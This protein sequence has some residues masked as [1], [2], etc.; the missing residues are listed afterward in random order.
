MN[1]SSIVVY[2][3]PD[4]FEALRKS[5][6]GLPGIELHYQHY[7]TGQM[8]L[9]QESSNDKDE[10]DGLKRIKALPHV[11]AAEMFYHCV[12]E[13]SD[14]RGKESGQQTDNGGTLSWV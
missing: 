10:M 8:V 1:L 12:E 14:Q 3:T 5:L 11:M 7:D 6:H 9:I 4:K 2:T 13:E